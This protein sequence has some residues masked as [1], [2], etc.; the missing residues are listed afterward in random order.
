MR[1]ELSQELLD[2]R[3]PL[4]AWVGQPSLGNELLDSIE[5]GIPVAPRLLRRPPGAT[6]VQLASLSMGR[7]AAPAYREPCAPGRLRWR[8][9]ALEEE[10]QDVARVLHFS[11]NLLRLLGHPLGGW[12][13]QHQR[14][15]PGLEVLGDVRDAGAGARGEARR[16]ELRGGPCGRALLLGAHQQDGIASGLD[17]AVGRVCDAPPHRRAARRCLASSVD[18]GLRAP[19]VS[20]AAA[21]V[22]S[23]QGVR[24]E[25]AHTLV[26]QRH[27]PE[28]RSLA[29]PPRTDD[30]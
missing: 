8:P 26:C 24:E 18:Y 22:A 23:G 19:V 11:E 16:A 12:P 21:A 3:V 15:R 1:L 6:L 29:A 10:Q 5:H 28:L 30:G 25:A 17:V 13:R 14:R 20:V 2:Q 27:Q 9:L 7:V 4:V